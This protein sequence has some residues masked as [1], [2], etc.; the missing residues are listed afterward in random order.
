MNVARRFIIFID[1]MYECHVKLIVHAAAPP[2]EI[3]EVDLD[4]RVCD[5]AFAFDRTRSRLEE[6]GKVSDELYGNVCTNHI[7]LAILV[8]THSAI[9]ALYS[10]VFPCSDIYL[11][12]HQTI[13][14]GRLKIF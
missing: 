8:C 1:A 3:F 10:D 12:L 11:F 14:V 13:N 4:N 5:E 2:H 9:F 6:M 7:L